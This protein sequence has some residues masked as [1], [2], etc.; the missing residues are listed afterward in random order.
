MGEPPPPPHRPMMRDYGLVANRDHLT[1]VFQPANPVAFYIKTSAKNGL[2]ENQYDGRDTMSPHERLSHFYKTCQ[3]CI[4]PANVI[5][6]Q[7]KLRLFSFTLSGRVKDTLLSIPSGTIQTW[8]ELEL[9][10]LERFFHMSRYWEKKHVITN[11]K[12]GENE[13]CMMP[14]SSLNFCLKGVLRMT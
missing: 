3:F 5:E 1:H 12:K 7:K 2:K 9:K 14:V 8:D 13:S 11:F 6:D 4:P 10:I